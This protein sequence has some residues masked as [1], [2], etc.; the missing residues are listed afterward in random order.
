MTAVFTN[1][2]ARILKL[3]MVLALLSTL[4]GT[5]AFAQGGD[6]ATLSPAA[7]MTADKAGAAVAAD[8]GEYTG[9][10]N[11]PAMVLTPAD[12]EAAGFPG[13]GKF[14]D[15]NFVPFASFVATTAEFRGLPATEVEAAA[16]EAGWL[17]FY[18]SS[19]G[20]PNVPDTSECR[21][22]QVASSFVNEYVDAAGAQ[23]AFAALNAR[24]DTAHARIEAVAGTD[25]VGDE[26]RIESTFVTDPECGL[27]A[28]LSILLRHDNLIG[29]VGFEVF[30]DAA[31]LAATTASAAPA[32][33]PDFASVAT[34][35]ALETLAA[36][37]LAKM[38]STLAAGDP[39]LTVLALRMDRTTTPVVYEREGY[40]ILN[41]ETP[42]FYGGSEAEDDILALPA[43]FANV[44][45]VYEVEQLLQVGEEPADTNPYY[46]LRLMR[47][48]D[49]EAAST[50]IDTFPSALAD[51][52]GSVTGGDPIEGAALDLGDESRAIAFRAGGASSP[53]AAYEI[54]VRVGTTVVT[55]FLGSTLRPD[56]AI[57]AE[58]A[59]AQIACL[60]A[61][62]CEPVP[63]PAALHASP[64][65]EGS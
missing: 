46:L 62:A 23:A 15:G 49:E 21:A 17:R 19:M 27:K 2:V 31:R 34:V 3:V 11:L 14:G 50:F 8:A 12:L 60:E 55:V 53:P 41:G 44:E 54:D 64:M 28:G 37:L 65:S 61:G 5:V 59:T 30:G 32:A 16:Q 10:L 24:G 52:A 51:G 1:S 39:G 22:S 48:A 45:E 43:V 47:F 58:L 18:G 42:P 35:P 38:E 7:T 36:R 20:V 4:A 56:L 33:A 26:S 29:S 57:V 6:Q 13:Y 63:M 25:V 9:A 40:R